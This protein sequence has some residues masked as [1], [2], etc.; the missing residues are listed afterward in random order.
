M[1]IALA[2]KDRLDICRW[3]LTSAYVQG[4]LEPGEAVYAYPPPGECKTDDHG[5]EVCWKVTKPLY[6]MVQA[7]RRF[8]R[9]LFAWL[10]DYGFTQCHSDPC[11]FT[12]T[13]P[14]GSRLIVGVYVDDC[15][16]LHKPGADIDQFRNAFFQRWEAT[17]EGHMTDLL[18]V[19]IE[20]GNDGCITL[21]QQPYIEAM[22]ARYLPHGP[23]TDIQSNS[24]PCGPELAQLVADA[25]SSPPDTTS[26]LAAKYSSLVGSLIYA[27]TQ[28]RPDITYAVGM[29]SR[30]MARPTPALM[31]A[32]LR[33]LAYLWRHRTVGLRFCAEPTQATA[34]S[35]A[36]WETYRSTSG[37]LVRW[38]NATVFFAS[39]AQKSVALSSAEAEIVALSEAAKECLYFQKFCDELDPPAPRPM[40]LATDN[41]AARDLS[42]N[43]EHHERT[44][45]IAR[46]HF[47]IRDCVEDHSLQ[48]PFVHSHDN[49]ADFFT[50]YLP[51]KRFFALRKAIMNL[52]CA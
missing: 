22:A 36:S 37:W 33:V 38:Q 18:S 25:S 7:G 34:Y 47:F 46:R 10:L 9:A 42:Y 41:T 43:P 52:P 4:E 16:I 32:A 11:V 23:P 15:V 24:T 21:H 3:D 5:N 1:L 17:D 40:T 6:G 39:K 31:S 19:Q 13:S 20:R 30:V 51:P 44:K 14:T 45:H 29:L 35:D 49:L 26:D 48:V 50:K 8:Q 2:A 27:A 12:Y 28:T